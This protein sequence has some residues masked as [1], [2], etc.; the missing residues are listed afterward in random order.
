MDFK[1]L[2]A[3]V[4]V[5]ELKSFSKASERLYLSQPTISAQIRN[6]EAELKTRLLSRTTK[7]VRL[8]PVGEEFYEDARNILAI[9][10]KIYR[11]C[12]DERT[13]TLRIGAST[14]PVSY[15]LPE[16][17]FNYWKN[18]PSFRFELRQGG[19]RK[20]IDGVLNGLHDIGFVGIDPTDE[21][22]ETIPVWQDRL[23]LITTADEKF[24]ELR[25]L[26]PVPYQ[27]LLAEPMILREEGSGSLQSAE[28]FLTRFGFRK[29]RLNVIARVDDT[30]AIK[31]MVAR[32]M[33][34]TIISDLAVQDEI[35]SGALLSFPLDEM[36]ERRDFFLIFRKNRA[37]S[38]EIRSLIDGLIRCLPNAL[39]LCPD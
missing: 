1:Q 20:I 32:G 33:G 31:R 28:S 29:V 6:L 18:R 23:V 12:F 15:L 3:F 34:V 24:R 27:A 30:E 37:F 17:L 39:S 5:A 26:N 11:R 21:A 14:I 38:P 8:T 2:A 7:T 13:L 25:N 9:Q 22:L 35:E 19:S 36:I 16:V 10:K 4:T